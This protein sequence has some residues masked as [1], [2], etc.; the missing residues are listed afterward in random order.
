MHFVIAGTAKTIQFPPISLNG[1]GSIPPSFTVA[2]HM[3]IPSPRVRVGA[4]YSLNI[5]LYDPQGAP[6]KNPSVSAGP[7][8]CG[9]QKSQ[10]NG[11]GAPAFNVA[12]ISS[13]G[14]PFPSVLLSVL[15]TVASGFGA[16]GTHQKR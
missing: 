6:R 9:N 16:F 11:I 5:E 8:F 10:K 12:G 7:H 3:A 4:I 14:I 15:N 2:K 13:N 1:F